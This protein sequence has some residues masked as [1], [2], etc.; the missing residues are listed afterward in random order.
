MIK[1][2]FENISK[3]D[4]ERLVEEE[5][6][7]D[8]TL[9]YKQQLPDFNDKKQKRKF[10]GLVSSFANTVGGDILYGVK[11]GKDKGRN[12]GKIEKVIGVSVENVDQKILQ[13]KD[14]VNDLIEPRIIPQMLI[15]G[16]EGFELGPVLLIRVNRS[17][18]GPHAVW[19]D[20]K[21]LFY[22]RSSNSTDLM[23]VDEIRMSFTMAKM[24]VDNIKYFR[25]ERINKIINRD[26]PVQLMAG[27][28]MVIH[29]L[30]YEAF[31]LTSRNDYTESF[32]RN[33][34]KLMPYTCGNPE[35][36]YNFDGFLIPCREK[37]SRASTAY[38]QCFE[39]G[40]LEVVLTDFVYNSNGNNLLRTNFDIPLIQNTKK[41]I[42]R[43]ISL[44][45]NAPIVVFISLLGVK[46]YSIDLG[47][48]F[49]NQ[50]DIIEHNNLLLREIVVRD[51]KE[52]TTNILKTPIDT[53][54]RACGF[55]RNM[56]YD[57]DGNRM[58]L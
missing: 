19:M 25:Q 46:G 41:C 17:A 14:I 42:D 31:D 4:I 11:E 7:E 57:E 39:S 47:P 3:E 13:I 30:P 49:G 54:W 2:P 36:R 48:R 10:L 21:A 5:R 38:C 43:I 27:P 35:P 15:K 53:I 52:S 6:Q 16:V 44:G 1:K 40:N 29:V 55:P 51:L 20:K 8:R 37:D 34:S 45:I 26:T 32:S 28:K 22:V 18:T 9:D 50:L 58:N 23:D 12:S 24:L 56:H 33:Y